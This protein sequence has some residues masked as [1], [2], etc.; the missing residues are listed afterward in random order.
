MVFY[1]NWLK[2]EVGGEK[3]GRSKVGE[4]KLEKRK[5]ERTIAHH[6]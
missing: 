3:K 6:L 5:G 1:T 2:R 4:G